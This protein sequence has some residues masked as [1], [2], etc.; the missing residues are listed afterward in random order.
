MPSPSGRTASG[1][2]S[3]ARRR[4]L[5]R[6]PEVKFMQMEGNGA[7]TIVQNESGTTPSSTKFG[8]A[9]TSKSAGRGAPSTSQDVARRMVPTPDLP[10]AERT[11]RTASSKSTGPQRRSGSSKAPSGQ[12]GQQGQQQKGG[13]TNQRQ[14][15]QSQSQKTAS[16][17]P[18]GKGRTQTNGRKNG[19]GT[20]AATQALNAASRR[21]QAAGASRATSVSDL[22]P[23]S[24]VGADTGGKNWTSALSNLG[25]AASSGKS[26]QSGAALGSP[27]TLPTAWLKTATNG[28]LHTAELASGW[29][30][31]ELTL[32]KDNG[33]VTVKTQSDQDGVA[34]SVRFS[35]AQL[36]SRVAANARQL[37]DTMQ[38]Q[39]G[40]DVDLSFAG[41]DA[42][43]SGG[44]T[45]DESDTR[46]GARSSV[47]SDSASEEEATGDALRRR[48][49]HGGREWIG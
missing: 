1:T 15:G 43:T 46:G 5:R 16:F 20:K 23:G 19:A 14:H 24:S 29:N 32:G 28:P 7:K 47:S 8:S 48:G 36:R 49:P 25:S 18:H 22:F 2:S 6:I 21:G 9:R 13:G 4:L 39:Y 27:R 26:G 33:T 10:T 12:S 35:D 37:Q 30:V 42:G 3:E 17:S 34:V 11:V 44:Q 38:G 41:G 45:P 31:M 40:S